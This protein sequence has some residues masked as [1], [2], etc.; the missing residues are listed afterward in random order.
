MNALYS[1]GLEQLQTVIAQTWNGS[2]IQHKTFH[3]LTL[4][5]L[6]ERVLAGN[7]HIAFLHNQ[8]PRRSHGDIAAISRGI[9][10]SAVNCLYLLDD[11]NESRIGA[12]VLRSIH[13]EIE[14]NSR[15]ETWTNCE[16]TDIAVAATVATQQ[17]SF[18]K[19]ITDEEILNAYGITSF[20]KIYW[21]TLI[22][23][24]KSVG[25]IWH[26]FYDVRYRS[27]STW[28][29]GDFSRI[30]ISPS[31]MKLVPGQE[32]RNL[33]EG[34]AILSWGFEI[35]YNFTLGLIERI[36]ESDQAELVRRIRSDLYGK[37]KPYWNIHQASHPYHE[38]I[39]I[40]KTERGNP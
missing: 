8:D 29:H 39:Q 27:Y 15:V 24:A 9:Y 30:I 34:L 1:L 20:G 40:N 3:K 32:S 33:T 6:I 7:F 28:Q 38:N 17:A 19:E 21:P 26:Y 23:R 22:D 11:P 5:F 35:A 31:F 37:V 36:G 12:F 25:Q 2:A 16:D 10:E 4:T 13:A 14:I 18:P